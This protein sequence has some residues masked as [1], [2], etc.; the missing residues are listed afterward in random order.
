M[1]FRSLITAG[2]LTVSA[3][4]VPALTGLGAQAFAVCPEVGEVSYTITNGA[5]AWKATNLR[6]DYLT[7]PGTITYSKNTTATVSASLTGTTSA[8]AGIIFA[9]A[10]A[11]LSVTVG[12]SYSWSDV[13]SYS[14]VVPSGQTKRLQQ[15]KDSRSFT[16]KKTQIIA[17]C[18]VRT[19]WTKNVTAPVKNHVYKWALSS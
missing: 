2:S 14:A 16:V 7:G 12:G 17:P 3:F 5:K 4:V 6:S 13:W 18:N 10:S 8:E 11:S 9:K 1:R 19:V 15:Y